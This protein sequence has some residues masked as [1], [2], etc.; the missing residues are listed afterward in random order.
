M[1]EIEYEVREQDLIA[2]NEHL[3]SNS[4]HIQKIMRRHQAIAPGIFVVLAL[5]L[6]FYLKDIPSA[7]YVGLIASAWGVFVPLYLK[8]NMR[9]QIRRMY[10]EE[11]KACILGRYKLRVEPKELVEINDKGET[12]L[13]W[14]EILRVESEKKYTYVYV[15]ESTALIIPRATVAQGNLHEFVKAA[16]ER[17]EQAG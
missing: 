7:I 4:E 17:I 2:F 14:R 6:F 1:T 13:S 5:L 10:T 9:Q 16:D 8:W 12:R 11:E 3:L 15:G